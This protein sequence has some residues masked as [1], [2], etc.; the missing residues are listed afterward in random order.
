MQLIP[1][2]YKNRSPSFYNQ[3]AQ[4]TYTRIKPAFI[5]IRLNLSLNPSL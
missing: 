5:L 3:T 4:L 1:L 2:V